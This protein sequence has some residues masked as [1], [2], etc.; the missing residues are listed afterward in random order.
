MIALE[1][2]QW[3]TVG[4]FFFPK[5]DSEEGGLAKVNGII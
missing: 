3:V 1:H 2:E 4:I 5:L